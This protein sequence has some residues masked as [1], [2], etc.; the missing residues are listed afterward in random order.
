[1]QT[2]SGGQRP[3]QPMHTVQQL[4]LPS[5]AQNEKDHLD[6]LE[7]NTDSLEGEEEH[8]AAYATNN[9]PPIEA[10]T[11]LPEITN[12]S[13]L[14]TGMEVADVLGAVWRVCKVDPKFLRER[15]TSKLINKHGWWWYTK[16]ER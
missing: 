7:Q 15:F 4:E 3:Q 2:C 5:P 16:A 11:G 12:T 8:K 9:P 14:H 6:F 1:M 13:S 10:V